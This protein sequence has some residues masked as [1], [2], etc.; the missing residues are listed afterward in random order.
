MDDDS[1]VTPSK[2]P[3]KKLLSKMAVGFSIID[4]F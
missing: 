1:F 3:V 2:T 4:N